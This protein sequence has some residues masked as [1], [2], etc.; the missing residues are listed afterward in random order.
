MNGLMMDWPL[1][2]PNI[3]RRAAQFFAEKQI[4]SRWGDG[5]LHRSNY[6]ELQVRVHRLM[7]VLRDLGVQPGDRVGTFAW[8]HQRHLE[9]YFAA[10]SVGAVLHTI[11]IRLSREQLRYI[12]NHAQDRLIFSDKSLAGTLAE[13]QSDLPAVEKY[14][15]MDDR[16]PEPAALPQVSLD[17]EELMADASDR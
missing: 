7:N 14:I 2:I 13:L 16:G 6:G 9:L 11:N 8:N 12:I 3:L 15:L 1:A 4:V 5:T 10:P 17:Y